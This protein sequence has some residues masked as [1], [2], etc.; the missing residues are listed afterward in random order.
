MLRDM[1]RLWLIA[2]LVVAGCGSGAQPQPKPRATPVPE[3]TAVART[4]GPWSAPVRER[5]TPLHCPASS[6]RAGWP[7]R[8]RAIGDGRYVKLFGHRPRLAAV[9]AGGHLL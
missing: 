9:D 7:S 2:L 5:R 1:R 4:P 6:A 8:V 3:R